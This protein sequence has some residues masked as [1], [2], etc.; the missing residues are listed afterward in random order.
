M[1][2]ERQH[3]DFGVRPR[4]EST[5]DTDPQRAQHAPLG[6]RIVGKERVRG[7]ELASRAISGFHRVRVDRPDGLRNDLLVR[8][9]QHY[10]AGSA[11]SSAQ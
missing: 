8:L 11:A 3:E 4:R 7:K 6:M 1:I 9:G 2:D 5:V 10:Y